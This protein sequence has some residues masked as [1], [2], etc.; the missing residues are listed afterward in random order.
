MHFDKITVIFTY[1]VFSRKMLYYKV[2]SKIP[3]SGGTPAHDTSP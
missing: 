3:V 2:I 1:S